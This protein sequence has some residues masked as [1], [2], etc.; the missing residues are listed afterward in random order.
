MAAGQAQGCCS[1]KSNLPAMTALLEVFGI[2]IHHSLRVMCTGST[3]AV[4]S[5][6]GHLLMKH[7]SAYR[8]AYGPRHQQ[9][10][11]GRARKSHCQQ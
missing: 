10:F 6:Q 7:Y 9:Q 4:T 3:F 1:A 11:Q 5:Q 2:G 8:E